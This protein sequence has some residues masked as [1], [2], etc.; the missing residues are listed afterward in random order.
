MR[1]FLQVSNFYNFLL[2]SLAPHPPL[3]WS[4]LSQLGE[5]FQCIDFIY[6]FYL[7]TEKQPVRLLPSPEGE[8]G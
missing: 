8:G 5:G 3:A 6:K 4:P 1:E 2:Y 7:F